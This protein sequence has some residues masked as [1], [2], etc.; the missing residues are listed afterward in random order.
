M[1]TLPEYA[2]LPRPNLFQP[3]ILTSQQPAIESLPREDRIILVIQAFKI[4]KLL[5]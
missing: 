1:R 3:S 4:D 5:R 2:P